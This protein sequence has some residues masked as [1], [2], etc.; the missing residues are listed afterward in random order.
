MS[1][2][3]RGTKSSRRRTPASGSDASTGGGFG[4]AAL[5]N[6]V[7]A[8][9]WLVMVLTGFLIIANAMVFQTGRHPAP[10]FETRE[11]AATQ[12]STTAVPDREMLQERKLVRDIQ[13][14]LRRL[15]MYEG[16]LD[17]LK[18]PATERGVRGYQRARGLA[19]TGRVDEPLL[20][21]LALDT[22]DG[23]GVS[24]APPLPPQPPAVPS[25]ASPPASNAAALSPER[26]RI[27]AIQS[28]LAELG[29]GPLEVDGY[30]GDE[31]SNAIRR[32]ELDRGLPINGAISDRIAKELENVLGRPLGG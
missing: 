9:G 32:F 2:G 1:Q 22:G 19:E 27:S 20:A 15:G 25:A 7:A 31:T 16:P 30:S 21:R 18:G 17:G 10:L 12:P 11:R 26:A 3:Q 14:E 24:D 13:I 23:V 5:D 6:P 8:G 4:S 29:Y 28:A